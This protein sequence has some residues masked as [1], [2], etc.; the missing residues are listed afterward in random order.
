MPLTPRSAQ[1]KK[2]S[3]ENQTLQA[4]TALS[5]FLRRI[6][7]LQEDM[8]KDAML[9][10]KQEYQVFLSYAWGEEKDLRFTGLRRLLR[11][12]YQDFS[13][14]GFTVWFDEKHMIGDI[15]AQMRAGVVSSDLVILFGTEVYR[16]KT[17]EDSKTNVKKE[18]DFALAQHQAKPGLLLPL[19]L[20]GKT[21]EIFSA[22][23]LGYSQ[24]AVN[25]TNWSGL[26]QEHYDTRQYIQAL[27]TYQYSVGILAAALDLSH[28]PAKY[29]QQYE[30]CE[31]ALQADLEKIY[32][33]REEKEMEVGLVPVVNPIPA[34]QLLAPAA[35][36]VVAPKVEEAQE[37]LG[38][39]EQEIADFTRR[40]G[41]RAKLDAKIATKQQELQNQDLPDDDREEATRAIQKAK[42][43]LIE[44]DK[45]EAERNELSQEI[46]ALSGKPVPS[47]VGISAVGFIAEDS[48]DFIA[49]QVKKVPKIR[50]QVDLNLNQARVKGS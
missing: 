6:H 30:L 28:A 12:F 20:E 18:L 22:P 19:L 4:H 29:K 11:A 8:R 40:T 25:A 14:A 7:T 33:V 24:L 26:D 44:W 21:K 41:G 45:L 27:T 46:A 37:A 31:K 3:E 32:A 17:Q 38:K 15:D 9:N 39:K 49:G 10:H 16:Q 36:P 1:L 47:K 5:T 2:T 34:A 48:P 13:E 50:V 43:D 42:K 35:M 23:G